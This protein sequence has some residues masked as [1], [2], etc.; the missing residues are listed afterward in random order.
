MSPATWLSRSDWT[1]AHA[2]TGAGPTPSL[3]GL[4]YPQGGASD[5]QHCDRCERIRGQLAGLVSAR[6]QPGEP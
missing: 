6:L 1:R 2:F 3:C 4:R 5:K